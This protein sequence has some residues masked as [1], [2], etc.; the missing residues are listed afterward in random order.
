[1]KRNKSSVNDRN[2]DVSSL[3]DNMVIIQTKSV[4]G[5]LDWKIRLRMRKNR[6]LQTPLALGKPNFIAPCC[7]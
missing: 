1:M 5:S 3:M 4:T 7:G 2:I 6:R